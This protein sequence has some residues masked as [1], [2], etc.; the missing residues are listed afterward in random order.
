MQDNWYKIYN[1]DK[2]K[3]V[4]EKHVYS[5]YFLFYVQVLSNWV[6]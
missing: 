5:R 4:Y 6:I 3:I 1:E 2:I